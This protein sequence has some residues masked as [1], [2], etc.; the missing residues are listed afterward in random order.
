MYGVSSSCLQQSDSCS[1]AWPPEQRIN[2]TFTCCTVT[3]FLSFHSDIP[4]PRKHAQTQVFWHG[5][6][7][8]LCGYLNNT[9]TSTRTQSDLSLAHG[10]Y[11]MMFAV[12]AYDT[13]FLAKMVVYRIGFRPQYL[14]MIHFR[15]SSSLPRSLRS[16]VSADLTIPYLFTRPGPSILL[17]LLSSLKLSSA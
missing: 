7:R 10:V 6:A 5:W 11:R 14:S 13:E 17:K 4:A 8:T 1:R 15:R 3:R 16:C 12:V 9:H 2:G